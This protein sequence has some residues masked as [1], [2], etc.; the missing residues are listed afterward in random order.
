MSG[1]YLHY[2]ATGAA[3]AAAA[4]WPA[5]PVCALSMFIT[6]GEDDYFDDAP[7]APAVITQAL[8]QLTGLTSLCIESYC[9]LQATPQQMA[10]VLKQNTG[11][12]QAVTSSHCHE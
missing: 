5:L 12:K 11:L 8:S 4:A 2:H 6:G 10:D 3:A 7:Q 1:V 9:T